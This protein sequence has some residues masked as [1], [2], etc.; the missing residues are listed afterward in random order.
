MKMK[1]LHAKKKAT[2]THD[3]EEEERSKKIKN[4]GILVSYYKK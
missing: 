4:F 1:V 2:T 3:E